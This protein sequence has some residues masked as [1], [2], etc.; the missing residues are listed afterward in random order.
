MSLSHVK[1]DNEEGDFSSLNLTQSG[2]NDRED[3]FEDAFEIIPA[4]T[5]MS[6]TSSLEECTTGLYLFL[7]NRFSDAINLIHPWAQNSIYHA[8]VYSILMVVKAVLT[9]EPQDIQT[10]MVVVKQALKTCNAFRRKTRMV[11]FTRVVSRQGPGAIK[12]EELHAEVCYAECLILKCTVMVIQD[13]SAIGFLKNGL[14]IGSSYQIYKDCQQVLTH[15]PNSHSK[16][17]K[18]LAGGIKFGLGAFNLLLSLVPL[19]TLKLLN[20]VGYSGDMDTGIASL[21]ESASHPHINTILSVFTLLFYYSYL[22]IALGVE[23]GHQ[24]VMEDLFLIYLKKFPNCVILKFFHARFNMLKGHFDMAQG[25]LHQCIFSQNEWKQ[26]HHLCYWELMW[27][28]IALQEWEQAYYYASLLAQH[29]RW[30][31]A[32]YTFSK[33]ML[34]AVL[35]SNSGSLENEDMSSLFSSVDSLRIKLL[36]TSVPIEKFLADKGHHYGTTTGWYTAQPL[37]EF[38]YAWSGF[39]VI[40]KRLD[41]MTSWL[42]V[43]NKGEEFLQGNSNFEHGADDI[44]LIHLLKGLCLKYLSKFSVAEQYLIRVVQREKLLKTDHYLVPYA[45][46]E[47]G[48]LHYVRGD[49]NAAVKY[50]DNIKNYKDYSM[51]ARLQFRTHIALEQIRKERVIR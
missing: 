30:S 2:E 6:L 27:C 31:K 19:K 24:T 50:L 10:G 21:Y 18:H 47:L 1:G 26:V 28:H 4:A 49:N 22:H 44:C 13:D 9:F 46:Y 32:V 39:R 7:N 34:L 5:T 45:Y 14:T 42:S 41:L 35:P 20:V 29:S 15:I 23:K 11:S 48:I 51:E 33:A 12:E 38:M 3:K 17:Y 40:S 37:L 16:T 36:G 25:I 8:L 43:I